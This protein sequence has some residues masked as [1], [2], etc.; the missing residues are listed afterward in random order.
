MNTPDDTLWTEKYQVTEPDQFVFHQPLVKS[1]VR[2][3]EV[4]QFVNIIFYGPFGSGKL[5][6][7]RLLIYHYLKISLM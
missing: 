7:A 2:L 1:L 4:Q 6:L 5:S 3:G